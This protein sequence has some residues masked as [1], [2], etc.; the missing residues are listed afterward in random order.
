MSL[1]SLNICQKPL[2]VQE[3]V[4][5]LWES[6]P[7][8]ETSVVPGP[9]QGPLLK[10]AWDKELHRI[11]Y[12]VTPAEET[13]LNQRPLQDLAWITN[14]W[15]IRPKPKTSSGAGLNQKPPQD[16]AWAIDLCQFSPKAATSA[17]YLHYI[18]ITKLD[19]ILD[20][21]GYHISWWFN[22]YSIQNNLLNVENKI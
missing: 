3:Q 20:T 19:T 12:K 11:R 10:Q 2:Q 21:Q 15:G 14:L 22:C 5:D 18:W 17:E 8:P 7:E 1:S 13:G 16:Q 4:Q 6:M 9:S